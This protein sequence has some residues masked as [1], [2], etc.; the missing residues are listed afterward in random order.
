M[1]VQLNPIDLLKW[2]R[3]RRMKLQFEQMKLDYSGVEDHPDYGLML[4]LDLEFTIANPTDESAK[5]VTYSLIVESPVPAERETTYSHTK[6][7]DV[8]QLETKAAFAPLMIRTNL[9][10]SVIITDGHPKLQD[11]PQIRIDAQISDN[12]ILNLK[13]TSSSH[14]GTVSSV[15]IVDLLR[16][17]ESRHD[18]TPVDDL[19]QSVEVDWPRNLPPK[20]ELSKRIGRDIGID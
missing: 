13:V 11:F 6:S 10:N 17:W 8:E 3:Q 12:V 4:C 19:E 7:I 18:G 15:A 14:R 9:S 5:D 20:Q 2:L 1:G 16:E